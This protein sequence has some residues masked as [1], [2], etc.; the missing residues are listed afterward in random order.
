MP[1]GK[2]KVGVADPGGRDSHPHLAYSRFPDFDL[3]DPA[4]RF[5]RQPHRRFSHAPSISLASFRTLDDRNTMTLELLNGSGLY[6][7]GEWRVHSSSGAALSELEVH[8]PATGHLVGS[9]AAA[10]AHDVDNA[11]AAA[12]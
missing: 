11:T 9:V 7:D 2:M 6:I 5:G 10:T 4:P 1:E 12:A 3:F 8:N